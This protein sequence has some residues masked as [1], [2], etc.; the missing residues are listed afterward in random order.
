MRRVPASWIQ[1]TWWQVLTMG[2][3]LILGLAGCQS[4]QSLPGTIVRVERVVSGQTLDVI[5]TEAQDLTQRVRLIGIDAPDLEQT[6]W[7]PEAKARLEALIKGERNQVIANVD[8]LPQVL[9]ESDVEERDS[10]DRRL[11]Y[12]WRNGTLLNEQLVAEGFALASPRSPNNKYKQRLMRA[13]EKARLMGMG[14]WN[15]DQP[16]RQTPAEFRNPG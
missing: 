8:A 10:A 2:C 9:L 7:G 16:M 12:V 3:C 6:P 5:G 15:P 13:Q 14:I 4:S 11:A 1:R